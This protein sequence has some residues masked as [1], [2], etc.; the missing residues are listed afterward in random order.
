MLEYTTT[1]TTATTITITI[2]SCGEGGVGPWPEG[3]RGVL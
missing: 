2:N 3:E 1:I